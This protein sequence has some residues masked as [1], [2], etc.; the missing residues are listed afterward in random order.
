MSPARQPH[1]HRAGGGRR[2]DRL[3]RRRPGARRARRRAPDAEADRRR[4]AHHRRPASTTPTCT[5]GCRS[6]WARITAWT[7]PSGRRRR[8]SPARDEGLRRA[9][10]DGW[11]FVKTRY[12]PDGIAHAA[13]LDFIARPLFVVT[14][15]GGLLNQPRPCSAAQL[16][17]GRGAATA[18]C[19]AASWRR[20]SIGGQGAARSSLAAT[21]RAHFLGELARLGI[22]SVQLIDETARSVR[23]AAPEGAAHRARAHGPARLSASRTGSTSRAG[24]APAPDW[25]RVDGVKY[26]H[27]DGAR[28]TP[29]RAAGDLR[30]A[31]SRPTAAS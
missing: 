2:A 27:D 28:I 20:R 19:A 5:S 9:S 14:S 22:T 21:A 17:R 29:L 1:G 10:P 18:S 11:L 26:F 24:Q 15:R 12:L 3:C 6:R 8:G 23:G 7:F 25:L 13:D 4:R 30:R 16:H 31:R